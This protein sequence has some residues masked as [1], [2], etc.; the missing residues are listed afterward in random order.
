[1]TEYLEPEEYDE[2]LL[3]EQLVNLRFTTDCPDN[4]VVLAIFKALRQA[5]TE[6]PP[7]YRT[8][9]CLGVLTASDFAYET[10]ADKEAVRVAMDTVRDREMP[11]DPSLGFN[12][13]NPG[14]RLALDTQGEACTCPFKREDGEA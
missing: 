6:H 13:L 2:R 10:E 5:H 1:M 9:R 12:Q 11:N 8:C 7:V 14:W 4:P 3:G